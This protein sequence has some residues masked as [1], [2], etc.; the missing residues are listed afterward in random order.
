V[1]HHG[2]RL[3]VLVGLVREQQR[4][5]LVWYELLQVVFDPWYQIRR[6]VD[7]TR[8]GV[9]LRCRHHE[10][11]VAVSFDAHSLSTDTD[12]LGVEINVAAA[13][14]DGFTEAQRAP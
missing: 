3:Q 13:Q 1:T 10:D 7:I 11:V 12:Q 6:Y 4:I 14:L 8:T 9:T 5:R 2:G